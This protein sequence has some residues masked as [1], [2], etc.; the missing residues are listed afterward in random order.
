M[1][2]LIAYK[3]DFYYIFKKILNDRVMHLMNKISYIFI[4]FVVVMYGFQTIY[5]FNEVKHSIF[6]SVVFVLILV[7]PSLLG[8]Y[9]KSNK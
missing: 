3:T 2:L 7:L 5:L 8:Y 4:V 9:E 6:G 1:H